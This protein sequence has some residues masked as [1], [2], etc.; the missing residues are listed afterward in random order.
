MWYLLWMAMKLSSLDILNLN[1]LFLIDLNNLIFF[2]FLFYCEWDQADFKLF[3]VQWLHQMSS[4]MFNS[5]SKLLLFLPEF[6][7][8]FC[9]L[10][11]FSNIVWIYYYCRY[12][13]FFKVLIA[14][15]LIVHS[16]YPHFVL[17]WIVQPLSLSI[18]VEIH[19]HLRIYL[20]I[21]LISILS[22]IIK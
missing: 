6:F 20:Q 4:P 22:L 19:D 12:F 18:I 16:L 7:H 2:S 11:Y 17:I 14:Y 10:I 3:L 9:A 8:H 15:N 13:L 21:I 1:L 5:F